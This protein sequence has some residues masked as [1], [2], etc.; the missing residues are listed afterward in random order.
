MR[1]NVHFS[2]GLTPKAGASSTIRSGWGIEAR[3]R[4]GDLLERLPPGLP[5]ELTCSSLK[6]LLPNTH[7]G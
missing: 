5:W 2:D 1:S 4:S 3:L 7:V 6:K